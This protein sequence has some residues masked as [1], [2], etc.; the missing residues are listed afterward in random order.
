[1]EKT[2]THL[3]LIAMVASLS[4]LA[5]CKKSDD[6]KAPP[7]APA[8]TAPAPSS[9]APAP[10]PTPDTTTPG[11]SSPGTTPPASQ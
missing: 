10:A 4:L 8:T 11:S 7:S 1:M 5:A 2:R 3:A 9:T 6:G